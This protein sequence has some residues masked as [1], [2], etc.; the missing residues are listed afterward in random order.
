[1]NTLYYFALMC[2]FPLRFFFFNLMA[3]GS[4]PSS[5]MENREVDLRSIAFEVGISN[6][7]STKELV[8][9]IRSGQSI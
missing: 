8:E 6:F 3:F 1:M 5:N 4:R 7:T 2:N 9:A